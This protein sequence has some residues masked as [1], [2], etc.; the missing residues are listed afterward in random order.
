MVLIP[1]KQQ[2]IYKYTYKQT[3]MARKTRS[4]VRR[5][6]SEKYNNKIYKFQYNND[7]FQCTI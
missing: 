4:D 1:I 5:R 7:T 6:R 3:K 2:L